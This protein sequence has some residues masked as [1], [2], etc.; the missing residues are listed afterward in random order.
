MTG[1]L[2]RGET[3]EVIFGG[4]SMLRQ[5]WACT[6]W[7][8]ISARK[9]STEALPRTGRP[10][11]RQSPQR[12]NGYDDDKLR[13]NAFK[14][15]KS[16]ELPLPGPFTTHCHQVQAFLIEWSVE[17][18]LYPPIH[19]H[20]NTISAFRSCEQNASRYQ[21]STIANSSQVIF[22]VS[23]SEATDAQRLLTCREGRKKA[24]KE[25]HL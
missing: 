22:Q 10:I 16:R 18:Y 12:N 19:S 21:I 14:F 4:G 5:P 24:R 1:G 7:S 17:T 25:S 11:D 6:P 20:T 15:S 23:Y 9:T 3:L 13:G 8:C 2:A